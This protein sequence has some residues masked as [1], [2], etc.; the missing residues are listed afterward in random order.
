MNIGVYLASY[1]LVEL[2][3]LKCMLTNWGTGFQHFFCPKRAFE[4]RM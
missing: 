1:I 2:L 3:K 4:V